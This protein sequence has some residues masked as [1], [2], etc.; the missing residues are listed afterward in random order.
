ML[1]K[2]S[3]IIFLSALNL[4]AANPPKV[5]VSIYPIYSI[6]EGLMKDVG[7]PELL[8]PP[9]ESP[10]HFNLL[11]SQAEQMAQADLFIWIGPDMEKVLLKPIESLV[12]GK[13]LTIIDIPKLILIEQPNKIIDPHIWLDPNNVMVITRAIAQEL[14]T[15]DPS[16]QKT[17]RENEERI[18]KELE[19]LNETI[20]KEMAPFKG[21]HSIVYHEAYRY[22]Q[23][24]FSLG[25]SIPI[26]TEETGT[27]TVRPNQLTKIYELAHR[28]KIKCIFSE[29][30]EGARTVAALAKQMHLAL[31]EIDPL[32]VNAQEDY[33]QAYMAIMLNVASSFKDCFTAESSHDKP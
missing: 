23:R 3:L 9:T 16:N 18:V 10:H 14:S 32:G 8:L 7:Q 5:L 31:R 13:V 20:A 22:F 1:K 33:E 15:L 6:V 11:P 26:V 28:E 17:Y 19:K 29:P 27:T 4:C 2:L 24:A 12:K 25:N 21:K 30:Q